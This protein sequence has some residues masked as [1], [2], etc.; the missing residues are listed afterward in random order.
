MKEFKIT[1]A[2]LKLAENMYVSWQDC[3]YGAPEINP[4]RPYGNSDVTSDIAKI[5][6]FPEDENGEFPEAVSDYLRGIHKSMETALQI[7]LSTKSFK[8][9]AYVSEDY[10]GKWKLKV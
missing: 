10:S 7:F 2:H 8:V 6:G 9:G 5:L 3:E 4:K 1:E